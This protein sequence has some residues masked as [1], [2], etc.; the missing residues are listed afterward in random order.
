MLENE[1]EF[2]GRVFGHIYVCTMSCL[3]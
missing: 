2:I 1:T 3:I